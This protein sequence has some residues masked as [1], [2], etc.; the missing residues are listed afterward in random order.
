MGLA[1][2]VGGG[3]CMVQEP[4]VDV[5][6][7]LYLRTD[8]AVF[9]TWGREMPLW[10]LFAYSIYLGAFPFALSRAARRGLTMGQYRRLILG[11]FVVNLVIELPPLAAHLYEYF[12][13]QPFQVLG[14]PLFWLTLNCS[15]AVAIAAI[16]YRF[17]DRFTGGR[18]AGAA[19]LAP[20]LVPAGSMGTGL[21]VFTAFN[22]PGTSDAVLWGAALVTVAVGWAVIEVCGRMITTSADRRTEA[23]PELT[24]A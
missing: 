23:T 22:S 6:G 9:E 17:G 24:Y 4:M 3:L 18:A 2:L 20:V 7:S 15:S 11:G 12:G 21:A 10:G 5:A 19:L 13:E 14:L 16:V 1:L 8:I